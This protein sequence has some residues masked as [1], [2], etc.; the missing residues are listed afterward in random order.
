MPWHDE[1]TLRGTY[2][3][4]MTRRLRSANL[5]LFEIVVILVSVVLFGAISVAIWQFASGQIEVQLFA[6][7]GKSL[8]TGKVLKMVA[9]GLIAVT[10]IVIGAAGAC[11]ATPSRRR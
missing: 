1:S 4:R 8:L 9:A 2:R 5:P 10:A 11:G 3:D 6:I 7:L